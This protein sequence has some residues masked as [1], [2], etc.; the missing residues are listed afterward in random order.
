MQRQRLQSQL[1][2]TECSYD[3]RQDKGKCQGRTSDVEWVVGIHG[4]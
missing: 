1:N 2:L 4:G 3:T